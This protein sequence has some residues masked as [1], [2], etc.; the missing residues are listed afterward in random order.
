LID[1]GVNTFDIFVDNELLFVLTTIKSQVNYTLATGL[2]RGTHFL[3]VQ[4]R[5]EAY[6]GITTILGLIADDEAQLIR[7]EPKQLSRHIEF[8]GDSITCGFGILGKPGCNGGQIVWED[9]YLTYGPIVARELNAEIHVE[10]WSGIG[11]IHNAGS[12]VVVSPNNMPDIWNR[13][14]GI[15]PSPTWNFANWRPEAV[16]INLGT[17][18]YD[19]KPSPTFS[20]FQEA[21]RQFIQRLQ[22]EYSPDTKFFLVCGP[23]LDTPCMTIESLVRSYPKNVYFVNL[24]NILVWPNDYGCDG[25][26]NIAG[27]AKMAKLTSPVVRSAMNWN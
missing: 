8:I 25:H 15:S 20:Q 4:R 7:S 27:H 21:Y 3:S 9:N 1:D 2:S 16:V 10:C 24:Q 18:D 12:P 26:P 17:N 11:L 13:T 14:L 19:S 23:M 22:N 6:Y 5:S